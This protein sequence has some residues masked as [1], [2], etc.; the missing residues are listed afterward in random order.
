MHWPIC[1][2]SN[3]SYSSYHVKNNR[4]SHVIEL[5]VCD[6]SCLLYATDF[7]NALFVNLSLH[8]DVIPTSYIVSSYFFISLDMV[9][10]SFK[11]TC[12]VSYK[13]QENWPNEPH[14]N[15]Y[16]M[17]NH[18]FELCITRSQISIESIVSEN[19]SNY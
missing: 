9:K 19:W 7:D 11:K 2:F 15:F 3:S 18:T 10:D 16:R 8:E 4:T 5:S 17:D 14:H 6:D 1:G 12:S 13:I